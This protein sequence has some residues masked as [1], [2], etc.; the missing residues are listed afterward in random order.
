M[1]FSGVDNSAG[2]R[3]EDPAILGIRHLKANAARRLPAA[4]RLALQNACQ[5]KVSAWC[6]MCAQQW[7]QYPNG[8][9][10]NVGQHRL[11]EF[12]PL[13]GRPACTRTPLARAFCIVD[14]TAAGSMSTASISVALELGRTYGQNARAPQP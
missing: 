3:H 8:V 9:V 11:V 5:H 2:G 6:H 10:K 12:W 14:S 4:L 7:C 1:N 13:S